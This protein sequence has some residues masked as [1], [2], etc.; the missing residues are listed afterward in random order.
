MKAKEIRE[1]ALDELVQKERDWLKEQFDLRHAKATGKL[2]NPL[3]L[4]ELR[5]NL[6]RIKTI[7]RERQLQKEAQHAGNPEPARKT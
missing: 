7:L 2:E 4:R 1:L 3:K 5:R 6:A